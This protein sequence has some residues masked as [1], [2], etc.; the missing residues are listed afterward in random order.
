MDLP[1]AQKWKEASEVEM[2]SLRDLEVFFLVPRSSVSPGKTIR[3]SKWVYK[4]KSDGTHK[5]RLV[6]QGWNQVPGR[7]CGG[8]YSPVCRLQ[9]IRT[10]LALAAEK[11]WVIYQLDVQTAFLDVDVDE[12]VHVK[13][14]PGFEAS[15]ESGDPFV[16]KLQKS[17][18]GLAQSP[19]NW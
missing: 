5:A 14:E 13:M 17:L 10:V 18:Y 8:T 19:Q 9:S 15:N 2:R 3:G 12:E 6:A 11:D 1:E 4:V 7:D 16:T